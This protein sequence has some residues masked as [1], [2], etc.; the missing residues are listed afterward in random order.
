MTINIDCT[1]CGE[2]HAVVLNEQQIAQGAAFDVNCSNGDH[3]FPVVVPPGDDL[4]LNT[5]GEEILETT[6]MEAKLLN[7]T[8]VENPT[9][10][11]S[12]SDTSTP[13]EQCVDATVSIE[14][15]DYSCRIWYTPD[16][17]YHPYVVRV[18]LSSGAKR[19]NA[20][21]FNNSPHADELAF[22]DR[23]VPRNS[24]KQ[25]TYLS[26]DEC[27]RRAQ[28][29][30]LA[31]AESAAEIEE[32][33]LNPDRDWVWIGEKQQPPMSDGTPNEELLLKLA[34][35]VLVFQTDKF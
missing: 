24:D 12:G 8:A 2:E 23:G 34:K 17:K 33:E 15:K 1:Q 31:G 16:H 14:G 13:I 35:G 32:T 3:T 4:N 19:K 25:W 30:G 29:A 9:S 18:K 20:Y 21:V 27:K 10:P 26:L 22:T 6:G 28:L 7:T 5:T 11:Y